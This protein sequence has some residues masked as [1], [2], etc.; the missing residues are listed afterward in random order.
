MK[1]E[2]S[3]CIKKYMTEPTFE[4]FKEQNQKDKEQNQK[5]HISKRRC[6]RFLYFEFENEKRGEGA[7]K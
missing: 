7:Y 2:A 4:I 1:S 3:E 6:M 5:D